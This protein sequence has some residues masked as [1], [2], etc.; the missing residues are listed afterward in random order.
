VWKSVSRTFLAALTLCLGL[1][2][3]GQVSVLTHHGDAAR[4]GA[5][6]NETSL[7]AAKVKS[8]NFGKLVYRLVD[9]DV[10]AQ[11]LIVAE[12]TGGQ[13]KNVAIVAT[14]NNSVYAFNADDVNPNST[15]FQ[16]WRASLGPPIDSATLYTAV[17]K[18][19][20]SDL[21]TQIGI[22]GTPVVQIAPNQPSQG[23]VFAAAKSKS[24]NQYSY[25]LY[26]LN[27]AD[28]TTLSSI[29]F[30]GSVPGTGYGSANGRIAFNPMYQLNRPALLLIGSVLYAA[31]GG[32][33]DSGP[34]HGWIFAIDVSNPKALRQLAL[35]CTT[36]NGKGPQFDNQNVEGMGGIWMSGA[37]AA[38]DGSGNVY[39]VT[40]N[41]TYDGKTEFSDSVLKLKLNGGQLQ[42]SD[43][44]TPANQTLLKDYDYDLGSGGVAVVPNGH[45]LIAGGK[46]GRL[47]LLD[48]NNLGKGAM[49][50]GQ[51]FVAT[52]PLPN[53]PLAYNIHGTPVFW[54]RGSETYVY[55]LGEES[56]LMQ[57]TLSQD[58][59]DQMWK[60]NLD[61]AAVKSSKETA[62]YPNFPAGLFTQNRTENVWMPGGFLTVSANGA[63]DNTGIVWATMPFASNANPMVVR[64]V[65]RAFNASDVSTGE[66]WDSESTGN[67]ADRLGQFAKFCPPVVANGKVYVATSQ[68]ETVL[69]DG[70]HIK[71]TNGDQP[72]LAIYGIHN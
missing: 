62:P 14:E 32:H 30:Q 24:G 45:Q 16:L 12:G 43:W 4:T 6:L 47:Y 72:A 35:L 68:Q 44:F 25:T 34:Y 31:F 36:P 2:L 15:I 39:V 40:G 37:G 58:P 61:A 49:P 66:L 67:D 27:L 65:L 26:A 3:Q 57:Y 22:T 28:G 48:S 8:G 18:P 42:V 20:C 5:N 17:G 29:P 9:G 70:R 60:F 33:C 13:T 55:L 63:T 64:G 71:A 51:S 69:E 56:P 7:T 53:P 23:V 21:T 50:S 54:P 59:S 52:R 1:R 41:G 19:T 11:P 46:E 10:Y 38:A